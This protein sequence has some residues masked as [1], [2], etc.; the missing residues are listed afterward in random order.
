M[1]LIQGY[2]AEAPELGILSGAGVQIENEKNPELNW[3]LG[4][5]LWPFER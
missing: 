3:N 1:K 2:G 5:E 4:P